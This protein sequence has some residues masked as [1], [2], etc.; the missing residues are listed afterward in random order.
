MRRLP[1]VYVGLIVHPLATVRQIVEDRAIAPALLTV[2]ATMFLWNALLLAPYYYS[3]NLRVQNFIGPGLALLGS[4][5]AI[6]AMFLSIAVTIILDSTAKLLGGHGSAIGACVGLTMLSALSIAPLDLGIVVVW[7][8]NLVDHPDERAIGVLTAYG[9]FFLTFV[10]AVLFSV[11]LVRA[12]YGL[13]IWRS[14]VTSTA[15]AV[16]V[17]LAA[18]FPLLY[19]WGAILDKV[20]AGWYGSEWS[21]LSR[22]S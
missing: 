22:I 2:F 10:W 4:I 1:Y 16:I 17:P 21:G 7:T 13:G 5:F 19:I 6:I 20:L 14:I 15:G 18:P 12:N 3:S 8:V 9:L 11:L